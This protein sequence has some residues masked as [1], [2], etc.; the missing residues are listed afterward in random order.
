[1]IPLGAEPSDETRED[2]KRIIA[3]GLGTAEVELVAL[4][5]APL[6]WIIRTDRGD[7]LKNGT[8]FF[9]NAGEG[10]FGVTAA[11]VVIECFRDCRSDAFLGCFVGGKDGRTV[12]IKLNER[13]IDGSPEV[14]IATFHFSGDEVKHIGHSV[15]T[16][17][18]KEWPPI[19]PLQGRGVA[20]AG[21]PGKERRVLAPRQISFG[22]IAATGAATSVHENGI[23]IQLERDKLVLAFG[24]SIPPENFDFGGI[25]GGPVITIV[26]TNLIRSYMPAGVIYTGPNTS[27]NEGEAIA[28]F[29]VIKARPIHYIR[30]DGMLDLGRWAMNNLQ[31]HSAKRHHA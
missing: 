24:E 10:V 11:H 20:Y 27:E 18:Q 1:M 5:A 12:E 8:A 19:L 9:L 29:E 14:D 22:V 4:F 17:F 28:G 23:S 21:F 2:A 3:A 15:L 13:I 7:Y 31:H 16:G 6:F 25:S 26:E 30:P